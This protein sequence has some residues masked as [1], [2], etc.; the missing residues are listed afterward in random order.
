V[1]FIVKN[2]ET[3]DV[4]NPG[5]AVTDFRGKTWTLEGGTSATTEGKSGHV[6]VTADGEGRRHFYAKVFDLVV[7]LADTDD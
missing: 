7:E 4:V 5:D 2:A 3:G 6:T 1:K